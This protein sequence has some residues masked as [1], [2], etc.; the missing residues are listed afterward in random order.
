MKISP[1]LRSFINI[2][3]C[4][5]LEFQIYSFP[6]FNKYIYL[7]VRGSHVMPGSVLDAR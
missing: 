5:A 1:K 4:S 2:N 6:S 3:G 7:C